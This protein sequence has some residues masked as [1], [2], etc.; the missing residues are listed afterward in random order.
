M[1]SPSINSV[2]VGDTLPPLEIP[3]TATNIVAGA[4]ASN[5]FTPVHHNKAAAQKAGMQDVFMNILTTQGYVSRF[6]T[7]W[8][9]INARVKNLS[10]KLG[11]PNLPGD[12]MKLSGNI[13]R[14][15]INEG[16]VEVEIA[17]VNSW[18]DHV[19]GSATVALGEEA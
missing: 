6:I 8:A 19:I 10:I 3:L 2:K 11:T 14:C 16:T 5:D 4:L 7:D 13:T 1:S 15:D 18:G 9:G 12:T 17:G